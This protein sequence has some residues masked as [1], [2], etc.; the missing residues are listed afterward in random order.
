VDSITIEK[1]L[2]R[3]KNLLFPYGLKQVKRKWSPQHPERIWDFLGYPIF[4]MATGRLDKRPDKRIKIKV[5]GAVIENFYKIGEF[6]QEDAEELF[7]T[8]YDRSLEG[9]TPRAWQK[10][11]V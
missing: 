2:E 10:R 11:G 9:H 1:E 5:M 3:V 8:L 4:I 7:S 6:S